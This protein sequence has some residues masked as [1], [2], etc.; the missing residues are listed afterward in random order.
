[1]TG[2]SPARAPAAATGVPAV[3]LSARMLFMLGNRVLLA[4]RRGASWFYLPG[5][6]VR[7]GESV[8]TALHR[9]LREGTGLAAY[10]LDFVGCIEHTYLEQ[11]VARYEMNVVFAARLPVGTDLA[12]R[13]PQVDISSVAIRDLPTFAF[14]PPALR[15]LVLAWLAGHRPVWSGLAEPAG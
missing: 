1:M 10:S 3:A 11:G 14:R 4:S 7:S 15:D 8:E 5:G 13:D 9:Q 2:R 12:S 6:N